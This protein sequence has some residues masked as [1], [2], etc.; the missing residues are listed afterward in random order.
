MEKS[1]FKSTIFILGAFFG[2]SS[3]GLATEMA[4]GA[5]G[6][7]GAKSHALHHQV[8]ERTWDQVRH[9]HRGAK[10]QAVDARTWNQ[11]RYLHREAKAQEADERTWDQVRHLRHDANQD[12]GRIL[13]GQ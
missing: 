3:V 6:H 9:I 10:E 1:V 12:G 8:D 4:A 7:A 13:A 11:V 2:A 5:D